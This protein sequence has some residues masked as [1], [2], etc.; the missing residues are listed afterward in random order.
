MPNLTL[1]NYS[2]GCYSRVFNSRAKPGV[3]RWA[4]A[5][6][7][8]CSLGLSACGGGGGGGGG[9]T[10]PPPADTSSNCIVG[11]STIGD[12]KI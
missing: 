4:G 1:A 12:C 10:S 5:I 2:T 6:L 8:L 7:I 11:T 9:G 3:N